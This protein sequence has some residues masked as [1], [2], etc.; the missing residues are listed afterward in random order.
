VLVQAWRIL[1]SLNRGEAVHYVITL[2]SGVSQPYDYKRR[3][4]RA[5]E[6][7]LF[8]KAILREVIGLAAIVAF[9]FLMLKDGILDPGFASWTRSLF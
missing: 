2:R 5:T 3:L 1:R 7:S 9:T 6:P 4:T 8:W